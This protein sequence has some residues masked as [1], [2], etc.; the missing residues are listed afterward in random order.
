M[1]KN[2][3]FIS[4][5]VASVGSTAHSMQVNKHSSIHHLTHFA[6]SDA[7][8]LK[9][10]NILTHPQRQSLQLIER[11]MFFDFARKPQMPP[12]GLLALRQHCFSHVQ[13]NN[14]NC[15]CNFMQF[16][17]AA[18]HTLLHSGRARL[19]V[20]ISFHFILMQTNCP[21]ACSWLFSQLTSLK[22]KQNHMK[23]LA[24]R[25]ESSSWEELKV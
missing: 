9:A 5:P 6:A 7:T 16:K 11:Y 21:L 4:L 12:R 19:Y 3:F 1:K 13:I 2:T 8:R 22:V 14:C 25:M 24:W 20:S 15:F 10:G 23:C 17:C 18:L